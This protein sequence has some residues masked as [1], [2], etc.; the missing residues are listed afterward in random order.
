MLP[1][2]ANPGP[3]IPPAHAKHD[4]P[5]WVAAPPCA[6]TIP[7]WRW[8]RSGSAL[9]SRSSAWCADMPPAMRASPSGPNVT[10]ANDWVATA[11]TPAEAHGTTAPTARNLDC[12]ATPRSPVAGSSATME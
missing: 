12:T 1:W 2:A 4:P 7:T 8:L 9:T 5:V 6:S 10:F 11:P 3:V